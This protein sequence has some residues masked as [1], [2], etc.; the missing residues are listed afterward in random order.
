MAF[1]RIFEAG[2]RI[3]GHLV[4]CGFALAVPAWVT[5]LVL[6]LV[7]G[8]STR[9][10]TSTTEPAADT[11]WSFEWGVSGGAGYFSFR[12]SLFID[13]P[14]DPS[15]ILGDDWAEGWVEPWV[16]F[17]GP[18]GPGELFGRAAYAWVGNGD[19]ASALIGGDA[20]SHDPDEV[21]LGYRLSSSRNGEFE[22]QGGR[23]PL[24]LGHQFLLADGYAD[25]GDRGGYWSAA[26][27]AWDQ[28]FRLAYTNGG[29]SLQGFHLE[30]DE[31][32]GA[33]S[34]P[35]ID[36]LDYEWRMGEED[37]WTLGASWLSL[38]ANEL[39]EHLDGAEVLNLRAY[40]RPGDSPLV[41]EAEWV[42]ED[43]GAALD[44]DAWYFQP[45]WEF[46][47]PA[48]QPVLYY[49][50]AWFEGDDPATTQNE[51]Y[52]PLY[53]GFQ[54]WGMPWQGEI[55]GEYF[56]ANSNLKS[57]MLR[58]HLSPTETLGSGLVAFNFE[59][60]QPGSYRNGVDSD[61]FG[62]ELDWYTDWTINDHFSLSL[63]LAIA[64]PG[65][66]VTEATGRSKDFK[67]AML[68]GLFDF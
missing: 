31:I 59:L 41:L 22:I 24:A 1:R 49:R 2:M 58:L 7:P 35:R 9:A 68:Y 6:G 3:R 4:R 23:L 36:G 56:M 55:A 19:E 17:A 8:T 43:N 57:H 34:E 61:E 66:A 38:E 12:D 46:Q 11:A 5:L 53:P 20:H 32:P 42:R 14:P 64:R 27:T 54:D 39:A 47:G 13:R 21:Y 45:Y 60:D 51:A 25:G 52:D 18:L 26:R 63:V 44:A 29:H 62:Q 37:N 40:V 16:E 33:D 30:R 65:D 10:E 48:W 15:G 67:Y 50:Y 28:A